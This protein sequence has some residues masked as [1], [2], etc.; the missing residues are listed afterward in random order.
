MSI[1]RA[2]ISVAT[3]TSYLPLLK[4]S[5]ASTRS[6]WVRFECKTAT[7]CRAC[8]NWMRDA[9]GAVLRAG[10]NQRAVEIGALEQSH[11]QIEFLLR[12]DG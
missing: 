8:F 3:M 9:V 1:P 11:E 10:E 2:A 12:R 4:P 6:R 7:E 5:S